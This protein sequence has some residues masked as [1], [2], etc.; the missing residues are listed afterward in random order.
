VVNI[1]DRNAVPR[2]IQCGDGSRLRGRRS[3][4]TTSK[5]SGRLPDL[6]LLKNP[7]IHC[8][9]MECQRNHAMAEQ[10]NEMKTH[11]SEEHKGGEVA[12]TNEGVVS[13]SKGRR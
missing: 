3:G 8:A 13:A 9:T 7:Q 1:F 6:D 10:T 4:G 2:A 5:S 11:P 12:E